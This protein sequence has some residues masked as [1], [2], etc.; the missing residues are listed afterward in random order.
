MYLFSLMEILILGNLRKIV[1]NV[2]M[3]GNTIVHLKIV[4]I[5]LI[6]NVL[7]EHNRTS[8]FCIS[9]CLMIWRTF[10]QYKGFTLN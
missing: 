10:H 1:R 6:Q 7:T 9:L 5:H 2:V 3:T 4:I 8:C